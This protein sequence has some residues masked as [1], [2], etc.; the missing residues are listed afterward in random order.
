MKTIIAGSRTI[1][2]YQVVLDAINSAP[3]K[4]QITEVFSGMATGPDIFGFRWAMENKKPVRQFLPDWKKLGKPAG[5][6]RNVEMATY[7]DA[8]IIVWDGSSTGTGHILKYFK[9]LD[10]PVLVHLVMHRPANMP[11]NLVQQGR[12]ES[13]E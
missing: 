6:I 1:Q 11:P 8:A 13:Y 10:P 3:F 4:D 5:I 2:S 9:K 7:A 12:D